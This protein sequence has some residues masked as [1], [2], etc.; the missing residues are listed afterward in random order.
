MQNIVGMQDPLPGINAF[1]CK[2]ARVASYPRRAK[3]PVASAAAE[4]EALQPSRHGGPSRNVTP[5]R[6]PSPAHGQAS[7]LAG[8][9]LIVKKMPGISYKPGTLFA[10]FMWATVGMIDWRG[11]FMAKRHGRTCSHAMHDASLQSSRYDE[12]PW[13]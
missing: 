10:V 4:D 13:V 3:Q 2:G 6:G 11:L 1:V 8:G 9:C 7:R 12:Q 5:S